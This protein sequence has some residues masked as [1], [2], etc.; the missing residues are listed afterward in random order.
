MDAG[1]RRHDNESA[2]K[3]LNMGINKQVGIGILTCETVVAENH[4]EVTALRR[5]ETEKKDKK[6]QPEGLGPVSF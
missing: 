4:R 6:S 5:H 3:S 2:Q 1:F